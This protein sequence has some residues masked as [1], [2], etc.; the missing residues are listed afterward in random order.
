MKFGVWDLLLLVVVTLQSGLI[1]YLHHPRWKAFILTL[2]IP[3]TVAVLAVGRPVDATNVFGLPLLVLFM[4]A[5][6]WCHCSLKMPVVAAIVIPALGCACV[7]S[8]VAPFISAGNLLFFL[9]AAG[10]LVL[11][12]VL[13]LTTPVPDDPGHRTPLPP[14]IKLPGI[15]GLVLIL[16]LIK[17][18]LKGFLTVFPMVTV[19]AL[20]EARHSLRTISR[21]GPILVLLLV[22][23]MTVIRLTQA[24]LGVGFALALGWAT[25][26]VL[27]YPV[28]RL[29]GSLPHGPGPARSATTAKL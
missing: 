1:A 14:Y 5:V 8:A 15:A 25:F 16:I 18:L 10:C 26:L 20:Y 17:G 11:A 13:L 23:M 12:V 21:Q 7:A 3:F 27:L 22:P 2:P 19:F 28:L 4:Y 24:R 6:R 9:G 29:T